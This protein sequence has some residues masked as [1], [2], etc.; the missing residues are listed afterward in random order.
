VWN[1][2]TGPAARPI[3][4]HS[5]RPVRAIIGYQ[6]KPGGPS[7][8][9]A[10]AALAPKVTGEV[11]VL[12]RERNTGGNPQAQRPPGLRHPGPQ[13]VHLRAGLRPTAHRDWADVEAVHDLFAGLTRIG[14]A[15]QM[16]ATPNKVG[17]RCHESVPPSTSTTACPAAAVREVNK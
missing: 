3:F 2:V 5:G 14:T 4:I 1:D 13:A 17:S 11:L 9:T 16:R 12:D 6:G 10:A 8:L 7:G 15:C